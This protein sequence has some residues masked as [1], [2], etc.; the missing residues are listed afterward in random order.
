MAYPID[1]EYYIK[2]KP[3]LLE[4]LEKDVKCWSPSVFSRYGEIQGYKILLEARQEFE[5]LIPQIPYIGGDENAFTKNLVDSARYLALYKAMK[6]F[7]KT[8]EEVGEIIY[9]GYLKKAS[10]RKPIPPSQRQT[11]GKLLARSKKGAAMSQEKRYPGDYVYTFIA[12]NGKNFDHGLDFTECASHKFYHVQGADEL[13]PYY[14]YLDF[15]AAKVRGFG[16]TRTMT[17]YEGH[18]RCNH[19]FKA[20]GKT[21][22]GWPPPFLKRK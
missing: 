2:R 19:R 16:F 5:K 14:C 8:A 22:A 4:Q 11:L 9:D 12:G 1:K 18:G 6:K 10:E 17:L 15:V 3:E 13:L 7:D 20:S 21:K